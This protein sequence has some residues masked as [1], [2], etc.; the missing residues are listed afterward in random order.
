MSAA[1]DG[2]PAFGYTTQTQVD[3]QA[4]QPG[5][6]YSPGSMPTKTTVAGG[7]SLRDW[8]AGQALIGMCGYDPLSDSPEKWNHRMIANGAYAMADAMLRA[9]TAGPDAGKG[10]S[11]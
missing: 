7:M 11:A 10:G 3:Y 2:G 9:R 1:N 5:C 8:F 4:M 6:A